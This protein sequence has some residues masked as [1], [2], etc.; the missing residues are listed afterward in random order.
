[1]NKRQL[2]VEKAKLSAEEQVL[3][4]LRRDYRQA[5]KR[6]S[7]QVRLK[8]REIDI[9]LKDIDELDE[10][11]LSILQSKIY[12]KHFQESLKQQIDNII[13]E[14]NNKN[15][16]SINSYLKSSYDLGYT[17]TMYDLAG[18]GIPLVM[19]INQLAMVK[20]VQL[21]PKV[22]KRLY[23]EYVHQLSKHIRNEV[24]RGIATADSYANIARNI[25]NASKIGFNKSMR[26]ARTEG[27]RVQCM[28][29]FDAQHKAM[30]AGADIMK[31]WD[32]TLDGRTRPLHRELDG[33]IR[34]LDEPFDVGG[35]QVMYPSAFGLA[36]QDIN[37][38]CALLQRARWAL[39]D[40]ELERLKA[41]AEYFGLD[42]AKD[43][44]AFRK[45]YLDVPDGLVDFLFKK[46]PGARNVVNEQITILK[47]IE[48]TPAKVVDA[49][50]ST[51]IV[52]GGGGS[53]YDKKRD[54]MYI[55]AGATLD[56]VYHEI[57][58]LVDAKV[59]N[60][61]KVTALKKAIFKDVNS[62]DIIPET[63]H[64][65]NGDAVDVLLVKSDKLISEYQGR[66]YVPKKE[67]AFDGNGDLRIDRML[68]FISEPY[69]EYM[70]APESF[71]SKYPAFYEL[72]KETLEDE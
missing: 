40:D 23:G 4:R 53:A 71:K 55:A 18:Q 48:N 27:H 36:S 3:A 22:S 56:E 35:I 61:E 15:Y 33:Q 57:G 49:M 47:A 28:A 39:N 62:S 31:Q 64:R 52:V 42:K 16:E 69:R 38:R 63:K 5:A 30:A 54:I 41:R 17:G 7:E 51:T 11:Q 72:M 24:S 8:S 70:E 65:T 60:Q 50:K 68:E 21:S 12:Q 29:A 19:P 9:L 14:L 6:V 67:D 66:I 59:M 34:E 2:E 43:F 32:A 44:E 58:H 46:A 26:I 20:A 13:A 25:S 45:A 10:V 1:M 37:C